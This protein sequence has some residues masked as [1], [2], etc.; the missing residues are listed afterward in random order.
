MA[1]R[2]S[3]TRFEMPSLSKIRNRYFLMVCSL[4][5]SSRA[6]SRLLKPVGYQGDDLLL[7]WSQQPHPARVHHVQRR[8]LAY[9]LNEIL[10][11]LAVGPLLSL[12]HALDAV[13]K[14]PKRILRETKT[15]RGRR[16]GKR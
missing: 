7:A 12:V 1:Y 10:H 8:N 11:L 5:A 14:Q 16:S 2:T 13:A 4:R 15:N 6:T 9:G 3:S